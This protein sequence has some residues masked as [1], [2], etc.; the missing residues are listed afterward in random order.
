MQSHQQFSPLHIFLEPWN[1]PSHAQE[2]HWFY[3][4]LPPLRNS[5]HQPVNLPAYLWDMGGNQMPYMGKPTRSGGDLANSTQTAFK[6]R[7]ETKSL[8]LWGSST[9]LYH[10]ALWSGNTSKVLCIPWWCFLVMFLLWSFYNILTLLILHPLH[11]AADYI[12]SALSTQT[13]VKNAHRKRVCRERKG[14]HTF[15][16]VDN[17]ELTTK[18]WL[19]YVCLRKSGMYILSCV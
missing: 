9:T 14:L 3:C 15:L 7:N 11:L 5:L 16:G 13:G 2:L 18:N 6:D 12:V 1:F 8:E 10:Y 17:T 19:F 4:H